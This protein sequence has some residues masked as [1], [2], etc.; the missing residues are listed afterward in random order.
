[1]GVWYG[2]VVMVIVTLTFDATKE[3]TIVISTLYSMRVSVVTVVQSC[4]VLYTQVDVFC[5]L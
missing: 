1:M 5:A 3:T 4:V 2:C